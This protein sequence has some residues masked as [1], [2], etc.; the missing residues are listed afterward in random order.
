MLEIHLFLTSA[1]D[2]IDFAG[3]K[4]RH[5]GRAA[6]ISLAQVPLSQQLRCVAAAPELCGH[7]IDDLLNVPTPA[8][9]GQCSLL[10]ERGASSEL[11]CH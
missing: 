11:L 5:L 10:Y 6:E 4:S 1:A 8:P 9:C 7:A 2:G 3:Y